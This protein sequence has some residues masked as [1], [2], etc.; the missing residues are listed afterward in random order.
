MGEKG[1]EGKVSRRNSD[2]TENCQ[3]VKVL[4]SNFAR[5]ENCQEGKAPGRKSA[6]KEEKCQE[7]GK[8]PESK[9]RQEPPSP[10]SPLCV[11]AGLV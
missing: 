4:G 11:S 3:E 10:A 5:K 6:R 2:R 9:L 8:V 7:G 1:Q